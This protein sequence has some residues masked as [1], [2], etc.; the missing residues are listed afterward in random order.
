[1]KKILSLL[2]VLVMLVSLLTACGAGG[3]STSDYSIPEIKEIQAERRTVNFEDM[4]YE[5]YDVSKLI[6]M[7]ENASK[8]V[9][10]EAFTFDELVQYNDAIVQEAV[11]YS[12][13]NGLSY[14]RHDMDH[15]DEFYD[16]EVDYYNENGPDIS[17]AYIEY[18]E[19]CLSSKYADQLKDHYSDYFLFEPDN[20]L[21]E[22]D[23]TEFSETQKKVND[24]GLEAQDE[25]GDL[26]HDFEDGKG[27]VN[28]L[29]SLYSAT[30]SEEYYKYLDYYYNTI[31]SE[32]GERYVEL[33]KM[34]RE[35]AESKGYTN[36]ANYYYSDGIDGNDGSEITQDTLDAAQMII[37]KFRFSNNLEYPTFQE[38][39]TAEQITED[40]GEVAENFSDK[41]KD[42]YDFMI[43]Y[44][45]MSFGENDVVNCYSTSINSYDAPLLMLTSGGQG[46]TL[47]T[48]VHE[49]GHFMD[50]YH[51]YKSARE[52]YGKDINVAEVSSQALELFAIDYYP[53]MYGEDA[54]SAEY[55]HHYSNISNAFLY[56]AELTKFEIEAYRMEDPTVEKLNALFEEILVDCYG[57]TVKDSINFNYFRI[58]WATVPHLYAS[59]LYVFDYCTSLNVAYQLY[60]KS[61]DD[62]EGAK[63]TYFDFVQ[64]QSSD[65]DLMTR[66]E[67][68]GLLDPFEED[69]WN[70]IEE[71][72][73]SFFG[74]E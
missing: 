42:C 37:D 15:E 55:S 29:E 22:Y 34:R 21:I 20:N 45:L 8:G 73:S 36:F 46:Q 4:E 9:S 62:L 59:P 72:L 51:N 67:R 25:I 65:D 31:N 26:S 50:S 52:G 16:A 27:E 24:L 68:T 57:E 54:D 39:L 69:S 49:F 17:K 44:N 11:L 32:N 14:V 5:R 23:K 70:L 38:S 63:E 60:I 43:K 74:N 19:T 56:Q 3:N 58:Q 66:C 40:L 35:L 10:E 41:S 28:I 1:M 48:A 71:Y 61:L 6:E 53:E 33:L 30:T 7:L 47:T 2:L 18:D 64:D 13:M 12:S